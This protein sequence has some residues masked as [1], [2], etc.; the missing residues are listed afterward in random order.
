MRSAFFPSPP[1]MAVLGPGWGSRLSRSRNDHGEYWWPTRYR[2]SFDRGDD[3]VRRSRRLS[4]DWHRARHARRPRSGWRVP[5]VRTRHR[6]HQG[7]LR[8]Q[9]RHDVVWRRRRSRPL[10]QRAV[11]D[12]GAQERTAVERQ[13]DSIEDDDGVLWLG[14][15]SGI[16]RLKKEE[17]AKRP[18]RPTIN[19]ATGCS[20]AP[21]ALP[22]SRSTK[23]V[24]PRRAAA[25]AVCGSRR[26]A[27][28]R[29]QSPGHRRP[30]ASSSGADRSGARR[31]QAIRSGREPAR[32]CQP[33]PR[34]CSSASPRSR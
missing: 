3:V 26:A 32:A 28:Y 21:M 25:T 10:L 27:G 34:T 20:P 30:P 2:P 24:G 16:A 19:F 9:K 33:A 22:A 23:A 17:I 15:W 8:G 14:L 11:R 6:Q 13:L 29:R 7:D 31:Y 1:P 4:M 5:L 18:R 12:P